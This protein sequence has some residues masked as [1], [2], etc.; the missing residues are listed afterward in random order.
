MHAAEVAIANMPVGEQDEGIEVVAIVEAI[1]ENRDAIH[2]IN[3]VNDG[4]IDN[5]PDDAIVE[6][7]TVVNSYGIRPLHV[8]PL[9]EALAAHLR[10][11]VDVQKLTVEAALTGDRRTALQAVLLDPMVEAAQEPAETAQMLDEMLAANARYLPQF[12]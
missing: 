11:H 6:V 4:A 1:L 12:A 7:S 3:T 2:I 10:R 9:P 5:L 8:G